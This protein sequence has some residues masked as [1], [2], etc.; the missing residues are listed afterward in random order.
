MPLGAYIR[1]QLLTKP[2]ERKYTRKAPVEDKQALAQ[3]LV[4]L[5]SGKLANN[6][7]Q[8]AKAVNSGSL[9]VTPDTEKVIREAYT[10][11]M[12]M[13]ETLVSALGLR[14]GS[15]RRRSE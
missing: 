5:G 6:L 14:K 1:E 11:I 2:E 12:W 4:A 15:R 13:R 8:L 7:N 9:P 3:L 10:E